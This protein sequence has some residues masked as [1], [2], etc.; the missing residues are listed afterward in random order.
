MPP[1]RS[2]V[3]T[4]VTEQTEG[5]A[6]V[7]SSKCPRESNPKFCP[8]ANNVDRYF[9]EANDLFRGSLEAQRKH[10][11]A[12]LKK[13]EILDEVDLPKAQIPLLRIRWIFASDEPLQYLRG[14]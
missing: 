5:V 6:E 9:L 14:I 11:M 8:L 1:V 3:A 4:P 10:Q 12:I 7:T 13:W 2:H